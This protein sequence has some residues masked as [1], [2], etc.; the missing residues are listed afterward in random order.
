MH[1][2]DL[3]KACRILFENQKFID[4][5]FL[6]HISMED[7]KSAYKKLVFQYHPDMFIGY[8]PEIVEEKRSYFIKIVEAYELLTKYIIGREIGKNKLLEHTETT[9]NPEKEYTHIHNN[10]K[11]YIPKRNLKFSEFLYYHGVIDWDLYIKSINWQRRQRDRIGE[12]ALRWRY[13]DEEGLYFVLQSKKPTQ[14]TGEIMLKYSI[15]TPFQL[16]SL[17][18][19]QRKEQPKIGEFF[20]INKVLTPKDLNYFLGLHQA[21]NEKYPQN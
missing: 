3:I 19:Q 9:K 21:H 1:S 17:L 11:R 2:L 5:N 18:F 13:L 15:V 7:V 6:R 12:I 8:P 16:K 20:L 14:L 10:K 4:T